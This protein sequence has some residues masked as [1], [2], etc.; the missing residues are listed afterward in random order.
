MVYHNRFDTRGASEM[1]SSAEQRFSKL[2]SSRGWSVKK[3]TFRMNKQDK[4][5]FVISKRGVGE[6]SVD[7]KSRKRLKSNDK[8]VNDD[9]VWLEIM[10]VGHEHPGW[11][12]GE[13]KL[14]AFEKDWG[15]LIVDREK[16]ANY[17]DASVDK[18]TIVKTTRGGAQEDISQ[19]NIS[20][21]P[22]MVV[23]FGG[24]EIHMGSLVGR[25]AWIGQ[26]LF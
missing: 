16:V 19:K 12:Y 3:S 26:A 8:L 15:F 4:I 13:A 9:I 11:L 2:A 17:V 23:F 24:R 1:G 21:A 6:L 22:Y 14:L 5:D 7:V 18:N 10:A 20:R 25:N